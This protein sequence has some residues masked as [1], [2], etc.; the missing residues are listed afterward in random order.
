MPITREIVGE[1]H[2]GSEDGSTRMKMIVKYAV[3]M[4][5]IVYGSVSLL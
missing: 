1:I 5:A 4:I 3:W 2:E